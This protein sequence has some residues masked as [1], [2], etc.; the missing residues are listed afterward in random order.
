MSTKRGSKLEKKPLGC[1]SSSGLVMKIEDP[2]KIHTP[3]RNKDLIRPHS[4]TPM[5]NKPLIRPYFWGG[6]GV[7]L[8][9]VG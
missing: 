6:G 4:G 5:V 2:Q 1:K 8:G 3:S 7:T 9:G